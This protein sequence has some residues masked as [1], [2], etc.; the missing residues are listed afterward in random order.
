MISRGY[1]Y[2]AEKNAKN[3][4]KIWVALSASKVMEDLPYLNFLTTKIMHLSIKSI[5]TIHNI[6]YAKVSAFIRIYVNILF[7]RMLK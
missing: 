2:N 1:A 7:N 4:L 3:V 6:E 5:S